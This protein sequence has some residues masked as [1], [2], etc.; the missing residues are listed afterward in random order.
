MYFDP[1]TR[2]VQGAE[3]GFLRQQAQGLSVV[4]IRGSDNGTHAPN[5]HCIQLGK[6]PQN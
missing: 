2:G 6:S 4:G 5:K 1:Q 3:G